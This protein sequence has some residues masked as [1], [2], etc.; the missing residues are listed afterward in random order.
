MAFDWNEFLELAKNLSNR[1]GMGYST[2]AANRTAVSRAY[3]AAFCQLRGY[4]ESRLGFQRSGTAQDHKRLRKYLKK[5]KRPRWASRLNRLREWRNDC[6]YEDVVPGLQSRVQRAIL[7][8]DKIFREL[9]Q[10][11]P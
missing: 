1:S 7:T 4:A 6:D 5:A 9:R 2:E 3:Y 11:G 10:T 8:V